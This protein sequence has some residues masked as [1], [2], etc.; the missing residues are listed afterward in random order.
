M[1]GE[2]DSY[3]LPNKNIWKPGIKHNILKKIALSPILNADSGFWLA[4]S[5]EV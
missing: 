4:N 5:R 3:R 2:V 1:F